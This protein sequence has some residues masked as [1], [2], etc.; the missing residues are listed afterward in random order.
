MVFLALA[1]ARDPVRRALCGAL[2][3]A[4]DSLSSG[5]VTSVD[6]AVVDAVDAAAADAAAADAAAAD[7]VAVDAASA[8]F[9]ISPAY[10]RETSENVSR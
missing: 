7:A 8:A 3:L 2:P 10:D 4:P 5:L 9:D 6:G 1:C